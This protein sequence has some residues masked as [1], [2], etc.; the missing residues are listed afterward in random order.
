MQVDLIISGLVIA[1]SYSF[2]KVK[3]LTGIVAFMTPNRSN[4]GS[5]GVI[6]AAI[7]SKRVLIILISVIIII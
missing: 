3:V 6:N 5:M 4:C 2:F 1:V 7:P